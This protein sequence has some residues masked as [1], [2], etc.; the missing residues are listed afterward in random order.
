MPDPFLDPLGFVFGPLSC[1]ADVVGWPVIV[2]GAIVSGLATA[3]IIAVEVWTSRRG[4]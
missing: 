3:S 1:I 2:L 4:S